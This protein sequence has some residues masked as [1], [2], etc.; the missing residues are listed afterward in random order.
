MTILTGIYP[1]DSGGPATFAVTFS[2]FARSLGLNTKVISFADGSTSLHRDGGHE[3]KLI[4]RTLGLF[5]RTLFAIFEIL[6]TFFRGSSVIA[7][8]LFVE[9]YIAAVLSGRTYVAKVPGDIVWERA[10]NSGSTQLDVREFQNEK[11]NWRYRLFRFLFT[12]SLTRAK[13]V[14]VPS[15]LLLELCL[16]WGISKDKVHLIYNSVDV[17]FFSPLESSEVPWDCIV[18]NRLVELKNVD[19]VIRACH[20]KQLSLLVVGDGPEMSNLVK[21]RD[22]L[23]SVVTFTGNSSTS[24]TRTY[25]QSAKIYILN[26]TVD[27]TAYSL[28]EA[29]S[30]GL[31][32]VA[33]I[34]TG[35]SEVIRHKTDGFLTN[36]TDSAELEKALDW[37][38]AQ[39]PTTQKR[40]QQNAR[41]STVQFFNKDVNFANIL[42]LV[43]R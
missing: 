3:V 36:S 13:A 26:S 37:I 22:Q 18:V 33:N 6:H 42:E 16:S 34:K 25:L 11:L 40:M 28:L 12:R 30:S 4:S 1:P 19:E 31:I 14:I 39:S 10:T 17:N 24:E 21:L 41:E 2:D 43:V 38:V 8:G 7:N 20:S 23:G 15:P 27:A 5:R 35:A 32:A 29:R 9:T